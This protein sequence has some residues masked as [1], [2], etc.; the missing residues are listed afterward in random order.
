MI[1]KSYL[2]EKNFI[3]DKQAYLFYGE[4]LGL[5]NDFKKKIRKNNKGAEIISFS[6]EELIHNNNILFNEVKNISLFEKNK[7][8]FIN[9]VNDKI[10]QMLEEILLIIDNHKIFLFSEILD[11][12][13]KIRALFEKSNNY[14][15][16]ACY[17]DNEI[18]IKKIITD[19]LKGYDG[20]TPYNINLISDNSALDRT[21]L[22]N[23]L[24][25]IKIYFNNKK[26]VKEKLEDL[27]NIKVT[28]NFANL[29]DEALIGNKINTNKLLS[30]TIIETEKISLYLNIINQRLNRLC[31]VKEE[32]E[33]KIE[34]KI[35]SLKPPI[36]WKDKPNFLLQA[37]KWTLEKIKKIQQ[38]TYNLE[39]KIKSNSSIDK[40]LL[41]KHLIIEICQTANA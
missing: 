4:N 19:E 41:M 26:I 20:L 27:L 22:N 1:Y 32:Q 5:K 15:V 34:V 37:K 11:K 8:I 3:L 24:D 10:F 39:L 23:E 2:I 21:N 13:S 12:K 7:I 25:K 6:Q 16:I 30:E 40:K 14:G 29:K 38:K 17:P 9:Q 18:S 33:D 28:E 36:F 31:E 35:N